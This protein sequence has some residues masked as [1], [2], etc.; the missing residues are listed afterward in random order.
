[1][2]G[3]AGVVSL[4]SATASPDPNAVARMLGRLRHRGPD[5]SGIVNSGRVSFGATRLAIHDLAE[6]GVMP[7]TDPERGASIVMN[8]EI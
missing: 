7:L 4:R 5:G 1:M 2:C 3:I 8:G 6:R